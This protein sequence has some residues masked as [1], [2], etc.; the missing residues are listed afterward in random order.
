MN[1]YEGWCERAQRAYRRVGV[2]RNSH[3]VVWCINGAAMSVFAL[4]FETVLRVTSSQL[5]FDD[6][7]RADNAFTTI[8]CDR[9]SRRFDDELMRWISTAPYQL[10]WFL[11]QRFAFVGF[12]LLWCIDGLCVCFAIGHRCNRYADSLLNWPM[13]S[14]MEFKLV[15]TCSYLFISH[16]PDS[17][18]RRVSYYKP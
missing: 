8:H 10:Q 11:C 1:E 9:R 5:C 14:R 4:D 3:N 7:M 16:F 17:G 2:V 15:E 18:I 13:K 12:A 6:A